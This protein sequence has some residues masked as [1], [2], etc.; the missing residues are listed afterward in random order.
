MK[1]QVFSRFFLTLAIVVSFGVQ[2]LQSQIFH[3]YPILNENLNEAVDLYHKEMYCSALEKLKQAEENA[4]PSNILLKSEIAYYTAMSALYNKQSNTEALLI[5][6][7]K[8]PL[9]SPYYN[10]AAFGYGK[11]LYSKGNYREASRWFSEVE[12]NNLKKIDFPE[13]FFKSGHSYFMT[14][15]NDKAIAAFRRIKDERN[16][17]SDAALYYYSHIE[18]ENRNY[19]T[20]S[21]GFERLRNNPNYSSLIPYYS[22]QIAFIQKNYDKVIKEGTDFIKYTTDNRKNEILRL[23]S[24]AYL[25]K[26]DYPN[27]RNYFNLYEKGVGK[28]SREDNFLKGYIQYNNKEYAEAAKSFDAAATIRDSL[29]QHCYYYSGDCFI[30]SNNK[31]EALSA[32][33]K[34]SK[35]NYDPDIQEGS[36]FN[37]AK[38]ALELKDDEKPVNEY[39]QR[40]PDGNKNNELVTYL[41]TSSAKKG[42]Y[43][44]A[45]S[46][47]KEI[48][49]PS[50]SEKEAIQN[51]AYVAG[52]DLMGKKQYN[53]AIEMFEFSIEN[54]NMNNEI[55][56]FAKYWTGEAYFQ[57]EDYRSALPMYE[58]MV[59]T[60]SF[61]NTKEYKMAHY[62]IAYSYFKQQ[63]YDEALRWF[64]TF[65][66][67][68]NKSTR[69]TIY[70][71]DSY[72]RLG[73]SY[74]KKRQFPF[75]IDNYKMAENLNLSNADYSAYQRSVST[76]FTLGAD[77]KIESL[78]KIPKAYPKSSM[79]PAVYFEL[80][81]TYQQMM[82]SNE[83]VSSFNKIIDSYKSSPF[84]SRA[85]VEMGLLELNNG[86]SEKALA[87]YQQVV[88]KSPDSPEAKDA[89]EGVK[90][91]Y[92]EQN[93]MDEYFAYAN[94]IGKTI[95]SSAEKDSLIFTAAERQYQTGNYNEALPAMQRYLENF[96]NGTNVLAANYYLA[97]CLIKVKKYTEALNSLNYVTSQPSN[98]FSEAAWSAS[99]EAYFYLEN[100]TRAASSFEHLKK[101]AQSTGY[102]LQAEVGMMR[103]YAALNNFAKASVP[104][105]RLLVS[106]GIS[107]DLIAEANLI[108]GRNLQELNKFNEAIVQYKSLTKNLKNPVGAEAQYR[109]IECYYALSKYED[110]EDAVYDLA[111]SKTSQYWIAKSFIILGDIYVKRKDFNQ[112]K[113][114]YKSILDGYKLKD[115]GIIEE[116]S[117]RYSDIERK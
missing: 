99:G 76:G 58:S 93:R 117:K 91:I 52:L 81:R 70:L 14:G 6:L 60:S 49:Y 114:T 103:S 36:F 38:L 3:A 116:V 97:D 71:A 113:A 82:K 65:N 86:N 83:A 79:L 7:L 84:Y 111:E 88:E 89:L 1:I 27:A 74:F 100:Y 29:T 30:R 59:A 51:I 56:S 67:L 35:L 110:A 15:E 25:Y 20:A 16:L 22:L 108:K 87:Y 24:E 13:F 85:L 96:P 40:Y 78:L 57:M 17:Y 9:P 101:I 105:A 102:I 44:D 12:Y 28:L 11:Y 54:A 92:L 75:A 95:K 90:N 98:Q 80:G 107:A 43:D 104:A 109:T 115:D 10:D 2:R 94:R 55:V 42:N 33:M 46:L 61:K 69:K 106:K 37:Y 112:A 72:N 66:T 34:A 45:L 31:Q 21:I 19:T 8:S 62:S 32:F 26:N 53:K 47:L 23:L 4:D 41:A 48:K 50:L 73:D 39:L 64:K 18:Y 77:A 68:E 63:N 5:R